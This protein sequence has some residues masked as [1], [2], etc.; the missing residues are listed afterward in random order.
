M[1]KHLLKKDEKRNEQ[2]EER[3]KL[4]TMFLSISLLAPFLCFLPPLKVLV[5]VIDECIQG[6]SRLN[7]VTIFGGVVNASGTEERVTVD[8]QL[9]STSSLGLAEG[10]DGYERERK[11]RV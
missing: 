7:V 4:S 9:V 2:R 8:P 3:S 6:G 11:V 5:E 10:Q 1:S